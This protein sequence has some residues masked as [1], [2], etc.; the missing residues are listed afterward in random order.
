MKGWGAYK[1]YNKNQ[2]GYWVSKK[3]RKINLDKYKAS[4]KKM[5]EEIK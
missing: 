1:D 4:I 3:S 2:K 5:S